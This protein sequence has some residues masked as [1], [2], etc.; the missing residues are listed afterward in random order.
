MPD[1]PPTDRQPITPDVIEQANRALEACNGNHAHAAQVLGWD[2]KRM[3]RVI[4][5]SPALR[6]KWGKGNDTE[7]PKSPVDVVDRKPLPLALRPEEQ[8]AVALTEQ[9]RKLHKSITKLGFSAKEAEALQSM[10]QFAGAHFQ[11]SLSLLH[12]GMLKSS[13]QLMLLKDRILTEYLSDDMMDPKDQRFWWDTF[14]RVIDQIRMMAAEGNKAALTRAMIDLKKKEA[15][16]GM[17][18]G[19][20]GFSPLVAVQVNGGKT[21]IGEQ[22]ND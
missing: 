14:F 3:Y 17:K 9:E 20:P 1:Q 16:G 21:T 15:E 13:A 19:K 12:G 18:G 10:E 7:E 4:R 5:G 8:V 22:Q 2:E 11:E 6:A